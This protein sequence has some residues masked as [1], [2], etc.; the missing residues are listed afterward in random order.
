VIAFLLIIPIFS[1]W[2]VIGY[3]IVFA[4]HTRRN[5]L[6]SALLAPAAGMAATVLL[7]L[8]LNGLG[9][10]VRYG[11]P[12]AT[13]I[14]G[15]AAAW[16]F[17]RYRPLIPLRRL[18]PFVGVLSI[19]AIAAGYPLLR[20]GFNWI[21]YGNDDMANYCLGA[22]LFLGHAEFTVP[23]TADIVSDRDASLFYWYFYVLAGIRHGAEETLA[24]LMSMTGLSAHEIFMPLILA[25]QLVLIAAGG[26]LVLQSKKLRT[27]AL[28]CCFA[29]SLSPLIT[30]GTD[31]QLIGQVSGLGMLAAT[32][33]VM[34]RPL[35]RRWSEMLLGGL[36]A[37]G[38][39]AFYPEVLSFLAISFLFYHAIALIRRAESFRSLI[40]GVI[41]IGGFSVVLLNVSI[42]TAIVTLAG[43]ARLGLS[44]GNS[45]GALFP[46]YLTPAGFAYLWGFQ[47]ISQQPVGLTLDIGIV[48]GA[49]LFL[50]TVVGCLWLAWQ[51]RPAAIVLLTMLSVAVQLYRLRADFGLFKIAMFMQPFLLGTV[52][53][54][55]VGLY[56]RGRTSLAWR[57]IWISALLGIVGW[58][59]SAQVFYTRRSMG[60][61]GTGLV[62]IPFASREGL[63][64]QLKAMPKNHGAVISDTSDIVVGKLESWYQSPVY[65]P[66]RDL[67]AGMI[68][69]DATGFNPFYLIYGDSALKARRQRASHF[70]TEYF[71]MHGALPSSNRFEVHT[72]ISKT[73]LIIE[74]GT[75][76]VVTNRTSKP[77]GQPRLI[78]LVPLAVEKNYLIFVASEFGLAYYDATIP[79]RV[80]GRVSMYQ[81]EPDYFFRGNS[82]ASLGRDSLFLIV[83]PSPRVRMV[84]EYTASLNSDRANRI[85]PA[86]VI[87]HE[88]AMFAVTGRGSARM[89]SPAVEPQEILGSG[90][91]A[92]DMGTWG[93]SFPQTR[94]RI[95]NLYGTEVRADTRKITGFT[96]DISLIS[97]E[98]YSKL[99]PPQAIQR[100]PND[101]ADKALEYSGIYEDGWVAESS[102]A[103]LRQ[104]ADDSSLVLSLSVPTLNGHPAASEVAVL[105]DGREVGRKSAT[106]GLVG[107]TVPTHGAGNRRVELRFDRAE[108]LPLPDNRP[109]S[110]Q[111]K[112]LGFQSSA[113]KSGER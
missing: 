47:S 24:W 111:I 22:K 74:T 72:G 60:D 101:V 26:A 42:L 13:I 15:A 8:A 94:S 9:L 17:R 107:I 18:L 32:C 49:T 80:L 28:L 67:Y 1:F 50:F 70:A 91:V 64:S 55:W 20:F 41:G 93:W 59:F 53:I 89:F 77:P 16:L 85:P 110:A 27:A 31:Y 5:L 43:Q 7:V 66:V 102:Y 10:P 34:L 95:M 61:G 78:R 33:S 79:N 35:R 12:A 97:D 23:S 63:I 6:Q 98:E 58:G 39:G 84:F 69:E 19:A 87:G 99:N 113:S 73:D 25:F 45:G 90:Y 71:D 106:A 14:L 38:T 75:K 2:A 104:A 112:Y 108:S 56:N 48:V 100:F 30:L 88:R 40:S 83:N 46:Y 82:M 76:M 11:G 105:L 81:V 44:A 62:E 4:L 52:A 68:A 86:S 96:R 3:G 109:V 21:S 37:S 57:S 65:F 36:L 54:I 92:L 51:R 29:S 103:V